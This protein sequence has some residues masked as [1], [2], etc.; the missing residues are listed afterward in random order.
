MITKTGEGVN[1]LHQRLRGRNI[2]NYNDDYGLGAVHKVCHAGGGGRG[3]EKV[4][5]FVT[6]GG[7]GGKHMCDVTLDIFYNAEKSW[8]E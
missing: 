6:E 7:W 1:N 8:E 2:N 3:S 5:Q 4:W